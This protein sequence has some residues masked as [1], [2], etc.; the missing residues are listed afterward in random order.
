MIPQFNPAPNLAN[1]NA[2]RNLGR[3]MPLWGANPPRPILPGGGGG[4]LWGGQPPI[5]NPIGPYPVQPIG[6]ME[7]IRGPEP[8]G[9]APIQPIQGYPMPP[10]LGANPPMPVQG[11]PAQPLGGMPDMNNLQQLLALRQMMQR[12]AMPQY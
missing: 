11:Q 10:G 7:P 2:L 3:P 5:A 12:S 6:P 9:P 8:V 4:E 1:L